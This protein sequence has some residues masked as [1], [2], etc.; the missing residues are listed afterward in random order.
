[1]LPG[2]GWRGGLSM[3]ITTQGAGA[4]VEEVFADQSS[5]PAVLNDCDCGEHLDL[6]FL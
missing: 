1:M 6:A 2:K 5:W 4:L 3:T